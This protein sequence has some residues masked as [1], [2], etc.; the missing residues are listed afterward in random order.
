MTLVR[1]GV[2][3]GCA[4]G[5]VGIKTDAMSWLEGGAIAAHDVGAMF[6]AAAVLHRLAP[7]TLAASDQTIAVDVPSLGVH[8]ACLAVLGLR[9]EERGVVVFDSFASFDA[10]G[11]RPDDLTGYLLSLNYEPA[12]ALPAS[13]CDEARAFGWPVDGDD[14]WPV[15]LCL[16]ADGERRANATADVALATACAAALAPLL[17]RH[18]DVFRTRRA[19]RVVE[20]LALPDGVLVRLRAPHPDVRRRVECACGSGRTFAGCHLRADP[21]SPDRAYERAQYAA[22]PHLPLPALDGRTPRQAVR[23][24]PGRAAVEQ[25]LAHLATAGV[26]VAPLRAAL[27]LP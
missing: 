9:G 25:V 8:D 18:G 7:W 26:D 10:F 1:S 11:E 15:V 6:A 5:K 13:M 12:A 20:E 24:G 21:A 4:A 3:A 14:A 19:A 16:E 23:T 27:G 2:C 17:E 22:W